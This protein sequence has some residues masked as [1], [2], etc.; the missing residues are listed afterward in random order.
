MCQDRSVDTWRTWVA[1]IFVP[2]DA[3][4]SER[5]VASLQRLFADANVA[6][7]RLRC[8]SPFVTTFGSDSSLSTPTFSGRQMTCAP[9]ETNLPIAS[10]IPTSEVIPSGLSRAAV[11]GILSAEA[12]HSTAYIKEGYDDLFTLLGVHG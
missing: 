5:R 1:S 10:L 6:S 3:G 11:F 7:W 12:T 4:I 2:S 8:V 9:P